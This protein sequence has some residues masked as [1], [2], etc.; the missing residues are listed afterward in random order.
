MQVSIPVPVTVA[1]VLFT[2]LPTVN[3]RFAGAEAVMV[4]VPAILHVAS[5]RLVI[6]TTATFDDDQERPSPTVSRRLW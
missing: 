5:P 4:T 1:E 6:E 3:C 2:P